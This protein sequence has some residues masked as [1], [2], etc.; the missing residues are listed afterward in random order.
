MSEPGKGPGSMTRALTVGVV[1]LI[2]GLLVQAGAM[3]PHHFAHY[4]DLGVV[5]SWANL[6][7][8]AN[9]CPAGLPGPVGALPDWACGPIR[10]LVSVFLIPLGWTYPPMPFLATAALW[11]A[12]P[13]ETLSE[14]HLIGRSVAFGLFV[15]G[16]GG[17][18]LAI[19]RL[20]TRTVTTDAVAL[21]VVAIVVAGFEWRLLSMQ[22]HAYSAGLLSVALSVFCLVRIRA[23]IDGEAA[24][25][26]WT[27]LLLGVA[28]CALSYQ[29]LFLMTGAALWSALHTAARPRESGAWRRLVGV[30]LRLGVLTGVT[31]L[32]FF[33]LTVLRRGTGAGLNWNAGPDGAFVVEGGAALAARLSEAAALLASEGLHVLGF[34]VMPVPGTETVAGV[35]LVGLLALA[36]GLGRRLPRGDAGFVAGSLILYLGIV[37]VLVVLGKLTLSPTRHVMHPGAALAVLLGIAMLGGVRT[38]LAARGLLAGAAVYLGV[39]AALAPSAY[40]PRVD[41]LTPSWLV[42]TATA[43]DVP[44]LIHDRWDLAPAFIAVPGVRVVRLGDPASCAVLFAPEPVAFLWFSRRNALP[45]ASAPGGHIDT[46]LARCSARDPE[47]YPPGGFVPARIVLE[48]TLRDEG[49]A[50][51]MDASPRTRNGQNRVILQRARYAP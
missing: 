35:V 16:L 45:G 29:S 22:A 30:W 40:A 21:A 15:A 32:P 38:P 25:V 4:D 42:E 28:A 13:A 27:G 49:V 43:E 24:R 47:A 8:L 17:L 39:V 14:A 3:V 48:T 20:G 26:P 12:M 41:L 34:T 11:H 31:V 9:G 19:R 46:M 51:E 5:F 44:V 7:V 37:L 1:A 2:V 6:S 33:A 10:G 23:W 18:W 50:V 36:L